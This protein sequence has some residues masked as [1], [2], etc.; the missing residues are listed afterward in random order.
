MKTSVA[1]ATL[2]LLAITSAAPTNQPTFPPTTLS[3]YTVWTG[4][5]AY[6]TPA[7]KILRP[8]N[9]RSSD[10]TTLATWSIPDAAAGKTCQWHFVLPEPAVALSGTKKF[11][12]FT[13]QAPATTDT[14]TWPHGN[15]RD[16]YVGRFA[17]YQGGEATPGADGIT[18]KTT[19]PCPAG[20]LVAAEFVPIGDSDDIEWNKGFGGPFLS[21][22]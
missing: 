17:A 6:N 3:Q 8:A 11:D 22:Y 18:T 19:F 4:A 15:L 21:Y 13:S 20:K 16:Q 5:I 10:I 9:S 1:A 7:G 2:S 12:L 14:K